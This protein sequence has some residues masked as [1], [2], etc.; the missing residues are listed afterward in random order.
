MQYAYAIL[1]SVACPAIQYFPSF[2]KKLH[3]FRK[4]KGTEYK[5]C[6]LVTLSLSSEP[7]FILRRHERG[8]TK[9]VYWSSCKVPVFL[10][11]FNQT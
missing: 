1:S 6:V 9:N 3:D 7:S 11:D 10:S 5:T 8:V 2:S 4:K